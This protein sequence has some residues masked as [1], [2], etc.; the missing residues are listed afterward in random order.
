MLRF[1]R[2]QRATHWVNATLFIVLML[3]ALPLYFGSVSDVVGRR[4]LVAQ[5]HLWV[6][7]CLPIPM[8]VSLI[9]PWGIR[10]RQDARRVNR[11][12][13]DEI[14]WLRRLG[15]SSLDLDKFNPG[16]KLNAIFTAGVTL[17]MLATGAML[18]W[19]RFFSVSFRTGA[20]LVHDTFAF[21]I[22]AIVIGHILFALTHPES[23]RSMIKGWVTEPWARRHA[24]SWLREQ[25][26]AGKGFKE[27][28]S[29]QQRTD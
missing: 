23:M 25:S 13:K 22:F 21:A 7:V 10:M 24:A 5:I 2:V 15:R 28:G 4:H 29:G 14:R 19:F 3:T 17:I 8:L 11:W 1:D 6:G 27:R 16:Q 20:T 9:G 18:Q 12:T 26:V